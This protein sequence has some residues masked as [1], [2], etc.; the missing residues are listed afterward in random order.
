MTAQF[1]VVVNLHQPSK[2]AF[3][4]FLVLQHDFLDDFKSV[5]VAPVHAAKGSAPIS[6][7]SVDLNVLDIPHFAAIHLIAA[8]DRTTIG[9]TVSNA[10]YH[11][12]AIVRAYDIIISG[13]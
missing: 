6:K 10:L 1:D 2:R 12:D 7:L 11:R 5:I 13:I 4:Y 9:H 3:P 8:M